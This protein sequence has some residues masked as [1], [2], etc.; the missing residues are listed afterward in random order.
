MWLSKEIASP[1]VLVRFVLTW[2]VLGG[3][4]Q[5]KIFSDFE[6]VHCATDLVLLTLPHG[7]PGTGL[8]YQPLLNIL[9]IGTLWF[10]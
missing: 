3:T 6:K 1:T 4:V 8:G 7:N 2:D 10:C 9:G 5:G